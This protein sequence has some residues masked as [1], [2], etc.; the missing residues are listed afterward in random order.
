VPAITIKI[1]VEHA[2]NSV[3]GDRGGVTIC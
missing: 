2:N 3:F 1:R